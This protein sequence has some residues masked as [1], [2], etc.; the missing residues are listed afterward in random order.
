MWWWDRRAITPRA[1]VYL[2][3]E[4]DEDVDVEVLVEDEEEAGLD[5][6]GLESFV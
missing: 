5:A 4:V 3:W 2:L 1:V 6:A